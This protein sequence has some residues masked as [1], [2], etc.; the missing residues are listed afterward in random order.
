MYSAQQSNLVS[1]YGDF[2]CQ[3][4]WDHYATI[5]FGRRLSDTRCLH[6]WEDFTPIRG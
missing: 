4:P 1:A 5:T 3:W 6:L 2:F